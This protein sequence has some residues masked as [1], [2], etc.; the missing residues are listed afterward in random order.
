MIFYQDFSFL[1]RTIWI[2]SWGCKKQ[3]GGRGIN[4]WGSLR[5]G[6]KRVSLKMAHKIWAMWG[7]DGHVRKGCT[8]ASGSEGDGITRKISKSEFQTGVSSVLIIFLSKQ[9]LLPLSNSLHPSFFFYRFSNKD[10]VDES[11]NSCSFELS[12]VYCR[13]IAN[14][15]PF[16]YFKSIKRFLIFFSLSLNLIWALSSFISVRNNQLNVL[17]QVL[18]SLI[19]L[20]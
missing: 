5:K 2:Q 13:I 20:D 12:N 7:F 1:N 14:F 6:L 11:F 19:F 3:F 16:R 18:L 4:L 9:C 10:N 8:E 17:L 15:N